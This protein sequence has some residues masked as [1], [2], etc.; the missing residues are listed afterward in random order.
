[1]RLYSTPV[2]AA[3]NISKFHDIVYNHTNVLYYLSILVENY[4]LN[5]AIL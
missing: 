1:M 3:I 4:K 5:I 2:S